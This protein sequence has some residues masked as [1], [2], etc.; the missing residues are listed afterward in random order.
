MKSRAVLAWEDYAILALVGLFGLALLSARFAADTSFASFGIAAIFI[1]MLALAHAAPLLP[2]TKMRVPHDTAVTL[3]YHALG[4]AILCYWLPPAFDAPTII[5]GALVGGGLMATSGDR[6]RAVLFMTLSL[7][8]LYG[9]LLFVQ[10]SFLLHCIIGF[11]AALIV[12][13]LRESSRP[14]IVAWVA[15][16]VIAVHG[17]KILRAAERA[18]S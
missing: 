14:E 3:H 8:S 17:E 10:G 5:M 13:R 9:M 7:A 15:V 16:A 12:Y 4:V 1:A 2:L 11:L 18:L 6:W